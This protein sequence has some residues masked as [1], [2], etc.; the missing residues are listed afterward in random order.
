MTCIRAQAWHRFPVSRLSVEPALLGKKHVFTHEGKKVEIRLPPPKQSDDGSI[1]DSE[2]VRCWKWRTNNGVKIPVEYEIDVVDVLVDINGQLDIPEQ[3]LRLPPRRDELFSE[4]QK[5]RLTSLEQQYAGLVYGVYQRW[6]RI[7]RWQARAPYLNIPV[8][9]SEEPTVYLVNAVDQH[10][11]W[12][13]PSMLV[14][15][16]I[17]IVTKE[18]WEGAENA[19]KSGL[20]P[21]IWIEY[22]FD[23]LQRLSNRDKVGSVLSAAIAFEIMMRSLVADHLSRKSAKEKII[24]TLLDE[25]N[26]RAI[27]SRAKH[28]HFQGQEWKDKF[29]SSTFNELMDWRNA[30][31]HRADVGYLTGKDLPKMYRA[32][33]EFGYFIKSQIT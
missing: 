10:R 23:A 7:I 1:E 20:M 12:M 30:I 9:S 31:I 33:L 18:A 19:L 13:G 11:F 28:M 24:T 21:P 15:P 26:I 3:A 5:T 22:A 17:A 6:I 32:L 2:H 14:A 8:S 25:V 4:P 29:K 27:V 16:A